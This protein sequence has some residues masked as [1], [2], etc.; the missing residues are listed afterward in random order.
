MVDERYFKHKKLPLSL[1]EKKS[2][3]LMKK[4]AKYSSDKDSGNVEKTNLRGRLSVRIKEIKGLNHHGNH[5]KSLSLK[6]YGSS[7]KQIGMIALKTMNKKKKEKTKTNTFIREYITDGVETIQKTVRD[8]SSISFNDKLTS[9]GTIDN[10]YE[11]TD[12]MYNMA[13][14]PK[15]DSIHPKTTGSKRKRLQRMLDLAEQR[16]QKVTR[17]NGETNRQDWENSIQH[18]EGIDSLNSSRIQKALNRD[19]KVKQ[20][21]KKKWNE[22]SNVVEKAK[23][24]KQLLKQENI[25][26]RKVKSYRTLK[27]RPGF[28]GKS[29]GVLNKS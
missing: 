12:L 29:S 19:T 10:D 28:E 17:Q 21:S 8:D 16:R 20:K 1:D 9:K 11:R 3:T 23:R 26:N 6:E 2:I 7:S 18:V 13:D 25:K 24:D 5:K 22:R 14:I 27:D 4:E 15:Y